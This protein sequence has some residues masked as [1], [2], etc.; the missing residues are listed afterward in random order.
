MDLQESVRPDSVHPKPERPGLGDS[1]F[2]MILG[3]VFSSAQQQL[4]RAFRELREKSEELES[5]LEQAREL[6]R[7]LE[8]RNA[9]LL[10]DLA[11]ARDR[12]AQLEAAARLAMDQTST[13]LTALANTLAA[14]PSGPSSGPPE[15]SV[16]RA[17]EAPEPAEASCGDAPS[18]GAERSEHPSEDATQQPEEAAI[19]EEENG[20][21]ALIPSEQ[22]SRI[23]STGGQPGMTHLVASPF[24]SLAAVLRFQRE[25]KQLSGVTD[26]KPVEFTDGVLRLAVWYSSEMTHL[27]ALLGLTGYDLRLETPAV[28][29]TELCLAS[30]NGSAR[31]L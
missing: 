27:G 30:S 9:Q 15:G 11:Q 17:W 12:S 24:D 18:E 14:E 10:S 31:D 3:G 16:A 28:D 29:G 5:A 4:E 19:E 21:T 22:P 6:N 8:D 7:Q 1:S 23:L 2:D 20:T 25:V 13:I 26:V